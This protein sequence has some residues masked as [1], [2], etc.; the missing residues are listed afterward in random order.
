M[1]NKNANNTLNAPDVHVV[2]PANIGR[3]IKWDANTKKYEVNIG[4]GLTITDDGKVDVKKINANPVP[5]DITDS[6]NGKVI[7]NQFTIDY[8][9]GL[10]EV[11]GVM[12]FPLKTTPNTSSDDAAFPQ[13]DGRFSIGCSVAPITYLSAAD[14]GENLYH[15]ESVTTIT[16]AELGMSKILSVNAIA[17]DLT[18]YRT[19][20]PWLVNDSAVSDSIKLGVHTIASLV[21]D[22]ITV[23]F[24][25]KGTKA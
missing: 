21:Q 5:S 8:G 4:E 2:T 16:A 3:G 12:R 19:E 6:T 18:G 11:N 20:S 24:Q 14:N 7:G 23:M 9:N 10:V 13:T 22:S 15:K 25:V 17:C 1:A